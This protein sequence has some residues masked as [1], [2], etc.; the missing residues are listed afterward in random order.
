MNFGK[1]LFKIKKRISIFHPYLEN[2]R[3]EIDAGLYPKHH[4]WGIDAL[5]NSNA[6][7]VNIIKND[8]FKIHGLFEVLL[9]KTVFKGSFGVKTELSILKSMKRNDILYSI[10]GPPSL[11]CLYRKKKIISWVFRPPKKIRKYGFD[12]YKSKNLKL[13]SGFC[14]LTKLAENF[15]SQ[16]AFSKFIPW[17]VDTSLF[18]G[19]SIDQNTNKPFFLASGKTGRDYKTLVNAATLTMADIRIIGPKKDKPSEIP[20]NVKWFDSSS[21]PPDKAIDYPTLKKWYAECVAVCIP[22]SGEAVDTCGYTNMLEAMAMRKPVIMTNSGSLHINPKVGNFGNLIHPNDHHG[23]ANSMN[24]LLTNNM[25]LKSFGEKAREII[26][27]DFKIERFN[28]DLLNLIQDI[29]CTL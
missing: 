2:R 18:D 20:Q 24:E 21:N 23:W 17:C 13:H 16:Y 1:H 27:R 22:L 4:L 11:S 8:A 15:F 28:N 29:L 12:S 9:D 25:K 3:S 19:I 7:D 14:C 5:E 10:G 26:E 6:Y